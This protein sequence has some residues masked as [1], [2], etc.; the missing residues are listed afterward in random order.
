MSSAR[1]T[2]K[3]A[4]QSAHFAH[5]FKDIGRCKKQMTCALWTNVRRCKKQM[6]CALVILGVCPLRRVSSVTSIC[7]GCFM[8][9]PSYHFFIILRFPWRYPSHCW[10]SPVHGQLRMPFASQVL[11]CLTLASTNVRFNHCFF[12][13]RGRFVEALQT[14][15]VWQTLFRPL[16]DKRERKRQRDFQKEIVSYSSYIPLI[17]TTGRVGPSN[18]LRIT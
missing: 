10:F 2:L 9:F 3:H 15:Q 16:Y 5:A 13:L 6:T 14:E 18:Y 8:T 17:V 1:C 7:I 11:N 12:F 4:N